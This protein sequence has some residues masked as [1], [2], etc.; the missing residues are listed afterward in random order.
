MNVRTTRIALVV[1]G[2]VALVAI[3]AYA[4]PR[5][6]VPAPAPTTPTA[7]ADPP[8]PSPSVAPGAA[9][10]LATVTGSG[11]AIGLPADGAYSLMPAAGGE[12]WFGF[13]ADGPKGIWVSRLDESA[14]S[15]A[16]TLD[17]RAA[18]EELA[19][20]L[21]G[22]PGGA[23]AS[24]PVPLELPVGSGERVDVQTGSGRFVAVVLETAGG[25]WR[26]LFVNEADP[27][28]DAVLRSFAPGTTAP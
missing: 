20:L 22:M 8:A 28:I 17:P 25:R 9:L 5:L 10:E 7:L 23:V 3:A 1:V 11:Y 21:G 24:E 18:A 16:A 4:V 19:A 26:L 15:E 12:A 6:G 27:A 13:G 2:A 14:G